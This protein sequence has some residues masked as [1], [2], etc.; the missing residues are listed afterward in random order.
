[1]NTKQH[2]KLLQKAMPI[3]T[4]LL[5]HFKVCTDS[6]STAI[7]DWIICMVYLSLDEFPNLTCVYMLR[8]VNVAATC[9]SHTANVAVHSEKQLRKSSIKPGAGTTSEPIRG[10][11][12]YVLSSGIL[13]LYEMRKQF[14]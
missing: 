8:D 7:T 12:S 4:S 3:K 5:Q 2:L 14:L 1:M 9:W 6:P 11:E 13:Q 10:Q